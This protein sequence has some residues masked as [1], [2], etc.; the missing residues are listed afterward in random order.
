MRRLTRRLRPTTNTAPPKKRS[1]VMDPLPR[2]RPMFTMNLSPSLQT[3]ASP[4]RTLPRLRTSRHS[5]IPLRITRRARTAVENA[6]ARTTAA[7]AIVAATVDAEGAGDAEVDVVAAE[8]ATKGL[9]G[10]TCLP[11]NML[12]HRAVNPAVVSREVTTS[13]ATKIAVGNRAVSNRAAPISAATTIG[14]RTLL[15]TV[16]RL[17]PQKSRFCYRANRSPSI[18][19]SLQSRLLLPSADRSLMIPG[20]SP[21]TRL[22]ALLA[23]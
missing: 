22:R 6:V 12:R 9:A 5:T 3:S 17:T 15:V 20:Q 11:R 13:V 10:A 19:A 21:K 14:A 18:A 2:N 23:T 8:D 7:V 16:A 1:Q 4:I